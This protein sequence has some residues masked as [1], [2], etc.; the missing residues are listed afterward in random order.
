MSLTESTEM[1]EFVER[2]RQG[3][4]LIEIMA[5]T[6]IMVIIVLIMSAVFH[7]SSV[8]WDGGTRKAEGNMSARAVLG[9]MAR[10][11]SEAAEDK[12]AIGSPTGTNYFKEID[13]TGHVFIDGGTRIAFTTIS[14]EADADQRIARRIEYRVSGGSLIRQEQRYKVNYI[15]STGVPDLESGSTIELIT[16][17]CKFAVS[18]KP[19]DNNAQAV[20]IVLGL[21]RSADVSGV[22]AWSKGPNNGLDG[23]PD[24]AGDDIRSQ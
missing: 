13:D 6:A 12:Y 18:G 17:V 2:K 10:E 16:N 3:F 7:Q 5:A 1:S 21:T 8:A 24:D 19:N 4:S 20:T 23:T 11:I 15:K 14:G 9:L 22:G